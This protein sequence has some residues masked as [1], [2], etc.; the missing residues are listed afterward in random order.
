LYKFK[1]YSGQKGI[2]VDAP[3][4]KLQPLKNK[5]CSIL[6]MNSPPVPLSLKERE[7]GGSRW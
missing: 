4:K 5:D 1:E 6:Q 2:F 3:N 7:G